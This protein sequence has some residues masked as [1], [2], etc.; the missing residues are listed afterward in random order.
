[1]DRRAF[2]HRLGLVTL[3]SIVLPPARKYWFG[4]DFGERWTYTPTVED[5]YYIAIGNP[6]HAD[7]YR[8]Y[9]DGRVNEILRIGLEQL[10][11]H[12]LMPVLTNRRSAFPVIDRLTGLELR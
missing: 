10:Q 3:G 9:F 11:Q 1:M 6:D 4:H 7:F 2:L 12:P 8:E 5:T